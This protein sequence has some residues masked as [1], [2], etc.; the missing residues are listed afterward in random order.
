MHFA[1]AATLMPKYPWHFLGPGLADYAR[2]RLDDAVANYR[3]QFEQ[4]PRRPDPWGELAWIFLDL[5][6][7]IQ[8]RPAFD[9]KTKFSGRTRSAGIDLAYAALAD[10]KAA[11]VPALMNQAGL[12]QP[13]EAVREIDRLVL[14]AIVGMAPSVQA[15]DTLR[16]AMRADAVP[17]VGSYWIFLG[18]FSWIDLAMLY[19]LAGSPASGA[20]LL[21]DAQNHADAA[22]EPRQCVP[23]DPL[24]R[25]AHR[26]TARPERRGGH[27]ARP[28]TPAGRAHGSCR[29]TRPSAGCGTMRG[30]CRWS[31]A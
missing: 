23:H 31:P 5:G 28:S 14:Q 16:D 24:P 27:S 17:W 26:G 15:I 7:P 4:D 1:R 10:G 3:L 9:R 18:W 19:T 21:D 2:G 25:R 13:L 8:A 20:P 6:L 29:S 11:A 12:D 30:W 22:R